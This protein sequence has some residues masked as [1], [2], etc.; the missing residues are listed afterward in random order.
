VLV[1]LAILFALAVVRLVQLQ[2][3]GG[4]RFVELG[5]AQRVRLATITAPRGTIYDR[6]GYEL[7]LSVPQQTIWADP[8]AIPDPANTA[9]VLAP[10]LGREP[11]SLEETLRADTRFEYLAR[12]VSDDL[13]RRIEV[14]HL[15]GIY[16][17]E[18]YR[19][20]NPAGELARSIL[21][22]VNVDG[23][24]SAGFELQYEDQIDGHAGEVVVERDPGGRTISSGEHQ[25]E[26]AVPGEDLVL[27]LDRA[28]QYEVERLLLTQV[29]AVGGQG[30]TAIVADSDSGEILALANVGIPPVGGPV[31]LTGENRALTA[32]Y[33][34]G[35]VNKVVTMAA[36]LEEGVVSP[37]TLVTV[38]VSVQVYDKE[39][40]DNGHDA[41]V[42]WTPTDILT[43]SSNVGAILLGQ[44][45]GAEQLDGYLRDFGF[46]SRTAIDFPNETPGI[47][48]TPDEYSGTSLATIAMGQGVS[49]T[50]M[51]MLSAFN[52]IANDGV[53]VEPSL[54][55]ATIDA[56]G[57][58][59]EASPPE[60]RRVVSEATARAVRDMMVYV[61]QQGT[62]RRGQVDGYL[63][64]GKTGTARKPLPEGG[65]IDA[66]G[67]YHYVATFAGFVPADDPQLSIIVVIDE[68]ATS[69]YAAHSAAPLFAQLADY[70][71]RHLRI[72]P[73]TEPW[74][75]SVP[76]PDQGPR[77]DDDGDDAVT[78]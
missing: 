68:P 55:R 14:L 1:V 71:L 41:P 26:P 65:Y 53:Y 59:H 36:A 73:P 16:L 30:G 8:A 24:G 32:T 10:M 21:G 34:P 48:P 75:A 76:A 5:D 63:A 51:Q 9:R 35:S 64:A 46:G 72:P 2:V 56:E 50:A 78:Q 18:E 13:A 77:P 37:D 38:P 42:Q 58:R 7:A 52:V 67:R 12:Q 45:V 62:G 74:T 22:S 19:R 66:N 61:V 70:S 69:I 23:A 49:V 25:L 29:Q 54:V 31:R 17:L 47:L 43:H 57:R 6:D 33:E 20:I 40:I 39:F 11:E 27:T 44:R 15:D 3:V 4:D 60:T 28:M